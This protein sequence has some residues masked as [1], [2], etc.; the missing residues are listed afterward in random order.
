MNNNLR[1]ILI[2]KYI[3]EDKS[4]ILIAEE[5]GI[6]S[7][8]VYNYL[9]KYKI[10][11]KSLSYSHRNQ[12]SFFKGKKFSKEH[13][14]NLSKTHQGKILSKK[15]K[16]KISK[17]N[18]RYW[19]GKKR[20]KLAEKMKGHIVSEET[21]RKQSLIRGGTGIPHENADYPAVFCSIK[22]DILK[23]DNFICQYCGMTQEEHFKKYGRNI[24]VHHIDYN[25]FNCEE[26]NLIT[27]CH[28]CNIRANY[29]R[30]YWYAY[31]KYIT[32]NLK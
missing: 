32:E 8:S 4:I 6:C 7:A 11:I 9:K 10:K 17:N 15:Q 13:R 21:K 12:I 3:K 2:E 22:K 19:A 27:L 25:K 24:E 26:S 20:P 16:Q 14:E 28:K 18:S 30:D 5:F 29:N 1:E 31:Y 23:R